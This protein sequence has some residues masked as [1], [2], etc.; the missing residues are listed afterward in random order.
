MPQSD[1]APLARLMNERFDELVDRLT[2]KIP[3]IS[4]YYASLSPEHRRVAA[5][6]LYRVLRASVESGKIS[7]FAQAIEKIARDRIAQGG[8]AEDLR[9]A[10]GYVNQINLSL[11]ADLA[12]SDPDAAVQAFTWLDQLSQTSL[13]VFM[14]LAQE[15]LAR[16]AEELDISI[17]LSER[18]EQAQR[19]SDVAEAVFEQLSRLGV[20]RAIMSMRADDPALQAVAGARDRDEN[21][22]RPQI[23]ARFS[24]D[25]L[26]DQAGPDEVY[27]L[28]QMADAELPD[29]L[30]ELLA[31]SGVVA[32]ASFPLRDEQALHGLLILG[33]R[34]KRLF[35]DEDRRFLALLARML[36]N[37]VANLL[38]IE[39]LREQIERAGTFQSL[40]ENAN[41]SIII[42]SL[43]GV[44]TYA[45]QAAAQLLEVDA[46]SALVGRLFRDFVRGDDYALMREQLAPRL[47]AGQSWKGAYTVVT[48]KNGAIPVESSAIPLLND[49]G[50]A[51]SVGGVLR[52]ERERLALIES[53]R[54]SN[55]EQQHTLELLRQVS[56]PLIPI[57]EGVLIMPIV[58]EIDERRAGQIMETLLQGVARTAAST[59]LLDITGVPLVDTSV[60]NALVLAARAVRL[61]G[62][63]AI[64]V[65]ITPEV[66]QTL[67][68]LGADLRELA[69]R[70]DLQSGITYALRQH[71][72]Q[73]QRN[74]APQPGVR[75][76]A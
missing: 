46:P 56:T 60:A 44:I 38:L 25:P 12:H 15:A 76:S 53:L 66:A 29:D 26:L 36:R 65:G 13:Q 70:G 62:A 20:D 51:L 23:G 35:S 63:E 45:N 73:L 1:L 69:T 71:G 14:G 16:H 40:V 32:L 5:A 72:Y 4:D 75:T 21:A 74:S 18:L 41:D 24:P 17:A 10:T 11:V 47:N 31:P 55:A 50:A 49:A 67:V 34:E 59:V 9:L 27:L 8:S 57:I 3:E 22:P 54:Q 48:S 61:L 19:L 52:D 7:A 33:Y 30:C 42:S 2:Q 37:R 28:A 6:N 64:L 39:R 58:G 68:G 43:D